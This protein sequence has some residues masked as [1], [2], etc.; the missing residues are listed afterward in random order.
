MENLK[1]AFL[2]HDITINRWATLKHISNRVRVQREV[3][4]FKGR[5]QNRAS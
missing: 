5:L 2:I 3:T 4:R 1:K